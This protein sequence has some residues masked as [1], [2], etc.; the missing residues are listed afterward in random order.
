MA[1]S[2]RR[3]R[4]QQAQAEPESMDKRQRA[5]QDSADPSA[6]SQKH[7]IPKHLQKYWRQRHNYFWKFDE[8]IQ[9]DEEGWYSVTPEIVAE[10][11]AARIAQLHNDKSAQIQDDMGFGRICVVDAFCGVGGNTIKFAT[12]C[13]HVIAIDIDRDRLEMARHN[14]RIYGV[15]DR[16]EFIHGDFYQLAPGLAADVVFLSPPWGGPEYIGSEVFDLD[17]LPVHTAREWLDRA[18]MVSENIACFMPRNCDPRQLADL[19]PEAPCDVEL[20]YTNGRLKAITAYYGDLALFGSSE[21]REL[22]P[23]DNP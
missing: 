8:G 15:E 2:G 13:E 5:D 7:H 11:T 20:N 6:A 14:A 21:P 9:I 17:S 10:D 19:Y 22:A 16:I 12:W 3:K 23:L 1:R 18:R 4:K